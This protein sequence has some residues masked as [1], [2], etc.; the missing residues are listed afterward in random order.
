M[1]HQSF[2]WY[3]EHPGCDSA[4]DLVEKNLIPIVE[5]MENKGFKFHK[6]DTWGNMIYRFRKWQEWY[7][8]YHC[9]VRFNR[10]RVRAIHSGFS[11]AATGIEGWTSHN[12]SGDIA[13]I[14]D[15]ETILRLTGVGK[16]IEE[17]LR[18]GV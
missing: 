18:D 5:W 11:G 9:D 8:D 7:G 15:F 12:F 14:E 13:N 2:N 4:L 10:H 16:Q 6:K 17:W 1:D 3:M